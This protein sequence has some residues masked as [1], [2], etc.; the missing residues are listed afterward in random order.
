M[1]QREKIYFKL[2][3]FFALFLSV[4]IVVAAIWYQLSSGKCLLSENRG[5]NPASVYYDDEG[6]IV[7]SEIRLS[8]FEPREKPRSR[9]PSHAGV[10]ESGGPVFQKLVQAHDSGNIGPAEALRRSGVPTT[11]ARRVMFNTAAFE[12]ALGTRERKVALQLFDDVTVV[13]VF[14]SPSS[15]KVNQGIYSGQVDGD[16]ESR[17]H[18]FVSEGKINGVI[19]TAGHGTIRIFDGGDGSHYIVEE[20]PHLA[21]HHE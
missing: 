18:F 6:E 21:S 16:P 7:D 19:E 11:R 10:G 20:K 9:K 12:A 17:I 1:R 14:Q 15:Y 5:R 13:G 2:F 8:D 4:A 3:G